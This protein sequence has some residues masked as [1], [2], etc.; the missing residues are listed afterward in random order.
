MVIVAVR[1]GAISPRIGEKRLNCEEASKSFSE[2]VFDV[3]ILPLL[4]PLLLLLL[5]LLLLM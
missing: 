1:E 4:L 2:P 3:D 5:L